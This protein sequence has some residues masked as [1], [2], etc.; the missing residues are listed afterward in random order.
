M[1][2][3]EFLE[4]GKPRGEAESGTVRDG[5]GMGRILSRE[6]AEVEK[7]AGLDKLKVGIIGISPGSGASFLAGCLAR[8]LANTKKH[9]PAVAELGKGALFDSFGMDKRF[10]GRSWFRFYLALA[11]NRSIRGKQNMDEGINWIL[12]SPWEEKVSLSFEQKLRLTGHAAGDVILCDFS[13]AEDSDFQLLRSMDQIIG[14]IDPMPSKMLAGYQ[15]LCALKAMEAEGTDITY[16]ISKMNK[17]VNRRQM[18]DFLR[19]RNPVFLPLVELQ[20]IYTAEYNCKIPYTLGAVKNALR[21]PLEE[22][23]SAL[24]F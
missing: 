12:R 22:I 7:C 20:S 8:Y 17:G 11:D 18:L 24:A 1:D 13:G 15:T 14:V 9:S 2:H 6:A 21:A 23:A 19:L 10:A 3:Q 5:V 16:V 4:K